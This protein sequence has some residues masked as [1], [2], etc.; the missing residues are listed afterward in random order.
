MN[1]ITVYEISQNYFPS[2]GLIP[3]VLLLLFS[4]FLF[5]SIKL[6]AKGITTLVLAFGIVLTGFICVSNVYDWLYTKNNIIKPY[7][8]GE[9]LTVVGEVEN[10]EPLHFQGNGTES[11]EIDGIKFNYSKSSV[12]YVGYN[13]ESSA[14]G[15]IKENGQNVRIGYMYDAVYD[16]NIILKLEIEQSRSNT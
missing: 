10:F 3:L 6:K 14:G 1:Y 8:E 7:F 5:K 12:E 4:F 9:Y 13:T 2:Y 15:Y 11:F 16:R